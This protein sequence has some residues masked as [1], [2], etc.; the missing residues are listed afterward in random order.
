MIVMLI[1]TTMYMAL[2][3]HEFGHY[4]SNKI[5]NLKVIECCVGTGPVILETNFKETKVCFRMIP[6]GGYVGTDEEGL[7]KINLTQYWII[8]LSGVFMNFLAC[9][10]SL[11]IETSSNL[12]YSFKEVISLF[13][14]LLSIVL[15]NVN[16]INIYHHE[17]DII[18]FIVNM[19]ELVVRLS[20][21][22]IIFGVN[23]VLLMINLIPIPALDGGQF[24]IITLKKILNRLRESKIR[25]RKTIN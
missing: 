6:I 12:I 5:F 19:K 18:S 7:S 9:I 21:W 17:G 1:I 3:I 15:L 11:R 2:A 16:L 10:I 13:D 8:I 23:A 24:L 14:E 25:I 22:K 4:I 20:I